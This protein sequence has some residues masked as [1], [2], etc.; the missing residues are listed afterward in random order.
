MSER[1]AEIMHS[2]FCA[3]SHKPD[4]DFQGD[5]L[6][7]AESMMSPLPWDESTHL[8]W[9]KKTED[10]MKIDGYNETSVLN[11]VNTF[12]KLDFSKC[13]VRK[14]ANRYLDVYK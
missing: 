14:L 4:D 10:E 8:E 7:Y 6:W 12:Q 2:L 11:I 9:L 1:I 5:C 13:I 3:K